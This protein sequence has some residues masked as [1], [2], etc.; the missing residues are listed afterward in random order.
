[1]K[2]RRYD[3]HMEIRTC[4]DIRRMVT[5]Y[6]CDGIGDKQNMVPIRPDHKN[7]EYVHGRC[8]IAQEGMEAFLALPDET[9]DR[10]T[11]DDIG[12]FAMKRL[13]EKRS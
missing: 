8:F 7:A 1:M 4:H 10:L 3:A 5:C 12:V 9:Q 13:M 2:L 6:E 11:L